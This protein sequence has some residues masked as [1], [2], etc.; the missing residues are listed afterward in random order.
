MQISLTGRNLIAYLFRKLQLFL[1]VLL[2]V[3]TP[4]VEADGPKDRCVGPRYNWLDCSGNYENSSVFYEGNWKNGQYHGLGMLRYRSDKG[5]YIGSF[6]K[7][8]R[9]GWGVELEI[10]DGQLQRRSGYWNEGILEEARDLID[11]PDFDGV[12]TFVASKIAGVEAD[13]KS[14]ARGA[15]ERAKAQK[16]QENERI[17]RQA[18]ADQQRI[19]RE[20]EQTYGPALEKCKQLGFNKGTDK[21]A[22]CVLRLSR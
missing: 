19:Q 5:A 15:L 20:Y 1:F 18:I 16:L 10:S 13:L 8:G 11:F 3:N 21:F 9:A 7:S 2:A 17:K 4:G 14:E 22:D 6:E 12:K